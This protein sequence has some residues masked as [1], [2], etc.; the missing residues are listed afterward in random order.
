MKELLYTHCSWCLRSMEGIEEHEAFAL[1]QPLS[2]QLKSR[3]R[4]SSTSYL[5]PLAGKE[6][7]TLI[8]GSGDGTTAQWLLCRQECSDALTKALEEEYR[9]SSPAHFVKREPTP[10]IN[11]RHPLTLSIDA[12]LVDLIKSNAFRK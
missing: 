5:I 1:A 9:P 2:D 11:M 3:A 4:R 7:P 8:L 6:V 12:S 10:E